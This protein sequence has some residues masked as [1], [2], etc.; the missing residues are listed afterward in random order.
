MLKTIYLIFLLILG[1]VF[2]SSIEVTEDMTVEECITIAAA[3]NPHVTKERI[4]NQCVM[5]IGQAQGLNPGSERVRNA[6]MQNLRERE[7]YQNLRESQL[8]RL[9]ELNEERLERLEQLGEERLN[10][11]ANLDKA[12]IERLSKL[13]G[14]LLDKL[15]DLKQARL[16]RLSSLNERHLQRV[17]ELNEAKIQKLSALNEEDIPFVLD[18]P[19][20]LEIGEVELKE[21]TKLNRARIKKLIMNR[22]PTALEIKNAVEAEE[23]FLRN[24]ATKRKITQAKFKNAKKNY[25]DAKA[26]YVQIRTRF[27]EAQENFEEFKERVQ[28]CKDDTSSSC[29]RWRTDAKVKSKEYMLNVIEVL[30][31]KLTELKGKL[32]SSENIGDDEE[33]D[34][35]AKIDKLLDELDDVKVKVDALTEESPR[36]EYH[37]VAL[38]LQEIT[39]RVRYR[40]E[41]HN[42]RLIHRKMGEI[43]VRANH[44]EK[45]LEQFLSR[46]NNAGVD[47][48]KYDEKVDEFS[49]IVENARTSYEEGLD[50]FEQAKD[51]KDRE[52]IKQSHKKFKEAHRY[53]Q[54]AHKILMEIWRMAKQDGKPIDDDGEKIYTPGDDLGVFVWQSNN[55][56][57][58]CVSGDGE[59]RTYDGSIST[60][61]ICTVRP[62]LYEKNDHMTKDTDTISFD[63]WVGSHQDCVKFTS[64]GDSITVAASFGDEAA[65]L[66]YGETTDTGSGTFTGTEGICV[67]PM[68]DDD[69]VACTMEYNPICGVDGV[70]YSNPCN[71]ETADVEMAYQGECVEVTEEEIEEELE[72][73]LNDLEEDS[74]DEEDDDEDKEEEEDDDSS[75]DEGDEE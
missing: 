25:E 69:V 57:T 14:V 6:I 3:E 26:R 22:K 56:W 4:R 59:G 29:E 10:R 1:A 60:D 51:E 62:Y 53:L 58:V 66:T 31:N 74:E 8:E 43:I 72:E 28:E 19:E 33:A 13:E 45:K 17:A 20:L 15:K 41:H 34:K 7:A 16:A 2:V 9:S 5:Q 38:E 21:A 24:A 30:S 36:E 18:N 47:T 63:G 68:P 73:E 67:P 54:E 70:T 64:L 27:K 55:V 42:E 75:E 52:L 32:E 50:L 39:K 49:E 44:L 61:G 11:I 46:L 23:K 37:A 12:Q 40:Y 71:L 48:S 65:A 35:I